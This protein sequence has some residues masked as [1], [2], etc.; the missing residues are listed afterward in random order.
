MSLK[1]MLM[2]GH[3]RWLWLP[4]GCLLAILPLVVSDAYL[5][6]VM[7]FMV[8]VLFAT[9]YNIVLGQ[10]GLLSFG[11]AGFFGAGAYTLA[12]ALNA[13]HVP[14]F[15]AL[16]MAPFAASLFAC[17]AGIFCVRSTRLFFALLT[18]GFAQLLYI[19]ISKFPNVTGG[20]NGILISKSLP[21]FCMSTMSFYYFAVTIAVMGIILLRALTYSAFGQKLIFIRE[22]TERSSFIGLNVRRYQL[23]ALVVSAFFSGLA[24][25]LMAVLVRGA[26]PSFAYWTM[27]AEP[28]MSALLGGIHVFYGPAVGVG[29]MMGIHHWV[30]AITTEWPLVLGSALILI[31]LFLPGGVLGFIKSRVRAQ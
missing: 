6:M 10:T 17:A 13:M 9:A 7:E 31:L 20:E 28:I 18:L 22:N 11:H 3:Q 21:S 12:I 15:L 19:V 30:S 23:M 8:L 5:F 1:N 24:G 4:L 14:F 25:A 29:L 26:H 2:G 27:S 16:I